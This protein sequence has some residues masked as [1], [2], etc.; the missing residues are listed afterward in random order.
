M[1]H[2]NTK[3]Q[4]EILKVISSFGDRPFTAEDLLSLLVSQEEKSSRAT[5]YRALRSLEKEGVLRKYFLTP[6]SPGYY[7]Y[8]SRELDC[9]EHFHM[10]CS[11]CGHLYHIECK[12]FEGLI[13]HL[14]ES[15]HFK[16]DPH[17]T[18]LYGLCEP[19]QRKEISL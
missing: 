9:E 10:V 5:V 2:Y 6:Q 3:Q 13:R 12:E 8:L 7:Q 11:A 16:I 14:Q 18:V 15:H 17:Q 1:S 19:C 4:Q